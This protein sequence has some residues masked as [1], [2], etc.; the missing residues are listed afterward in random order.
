MRDSK[1]VDA[2]SMVEPA[3]TKVPDEKAHFVLLHRAILGLPGSDVSVCKVVAE[4][5]YE[6]TQDL[7]RRA[8]AI[9]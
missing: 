3:C 6:L 4:R 1:K 5:P 9:S 7:G 2:S 8:R